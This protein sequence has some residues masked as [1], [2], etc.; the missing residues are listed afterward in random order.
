MRRGEQ[1]Q[2]VLEGVQKKTEA[3]RPRM[4][5]QFR[6]RASQIG[7]VLVGAPDGAQIPLQELAT[8]KE[9]NG[10]SFIYRENNPRYIGVQFSVEGRALALC[11]M[12]SPQ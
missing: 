4:Q 2:N 6:C 5:P 8:I 10:A 3:V 1:T 9:S 12:V 11:M 7:N